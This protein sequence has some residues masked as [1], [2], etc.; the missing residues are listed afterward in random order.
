[1]ITYSII[2]KS[3]LEGAHRLDA[4]YYQP[5]YFI[6]FSKGQWESIGD[7]LSSCQYGISQSMN[8][9]KNG[10]PIFKMDNIHHGFLVDDEVRFTDIPKATFTEFQLKKDDVLFNRVNSE[11]FV[12]RTGIYKLDEL[13]SVFAS[14]LIRIQTKRGGDILPDYLNVFLNS[15]YGIRQIRKFSRRAVN[16]A[17]VNAEELKRIKI[18][19]VPMS[20]QEKIAE[21]SNESWRES[22]RSKSLYAQAEHLLLGEL[23]LTNSREEGDLW[24][25]VHFSDIKNAGR[26]DAEYFQSDF[27]KVRQK[28]QD[29]KM[30]QLGDLVTMKKGFEPGSGA[31]QEDGKLFIRVSSMSKDGIT[32]KDQKFLSEKIYKELK[33]DYQPKVGEILLTKDAT[34]GV[35]YVLKEDLEGIVSGGILRLKLKE[36]I[37]P[38][39]LAFCINSIVGKS[40]VERDAGGSVIKH[41]KPEQIKAMVIPILSRGTQQKIADLVRASHEARKKAKGLLEEAKRKVE[42]MIETAH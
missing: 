42:E 8:D 18:A 31:Y 14:Y 39:Y 33:G 12:G 6:D 17:N 11:E 10:Y 41:W 35:A 37:D 4:E 25:V 1:M 9:E 21:L 24:S 38:E 7:V 20:E 34:P 2:K 19:V 5:E 26:M 29:Q 30:A 22:Q 3:E 23:G 15:A 13:P 27:E 16:Q 40:Q 36:L 28:L 32:E